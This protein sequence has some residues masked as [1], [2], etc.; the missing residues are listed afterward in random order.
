M[1]TRMDAAAPFPGPVRRP[2]QKML[3][4][5]CCTRWAGEAVAARQTGLLAASSGVGAGLAGSTIGATIAFVHTRRTAGAGL[6]ARQSAQHCCMQET[7]VVCTHLVH[8]HTL[9]HWLLPTPSRCLARRRRTDGGCR[10]WRR[11]PQGRSCR[12]RRQSLHKHT[13]MRTSGHGMAVQPPA[14]L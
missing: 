4:L 14:L 7:G 13:P 1:V 11:C 8:S 6:Q 12:S 5:T 2:W 9:H 3:L 10:R